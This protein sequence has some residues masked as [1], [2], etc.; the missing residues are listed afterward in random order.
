L[1]KKLAEY[2]KAGKPFHFPVAILTNLVFI[3]RTYSHF[4]NMKKEISYLVESNSNNRPN[5]LQPLLSGNTESLE[6]EAQPLPIHDDIPTN[7]VKVWEILEDLGPISTNTAESVERILSDFPTLNESDILQA[8]LL[9]CNNSTGSDDR[10]TRAINYTY[11]AT[12]THDWNPLLNDNNPKEANITWKVNNFLEICNKKYKIDWSNVVAALDR[13]HL[14]F[15]D[16]QA[17]VFLFKSFQ[18]FKKVPGF[19]F[20]ARL[21]LGKWRNFNSQINFV[22]NMISAA[23]PE[24][25]FFNEVQ[26][27]TVSSDLYSERK[28]AALDPPVLQ[29]FSSLELLETMIELSDS[30]YYTEIRGLFDLPLEKC[31]DLL[32]YSLLEINPRTGIELLNELYTN[33]VLHYISNYTSSKSIFDIIWKANP[34]ILVNAFAELYNKNDYPI[35]INTILEIIQ[36]IPDSLLTVLNSRDYEFAIAL[37]VSASKTNLVNPED[38]IPNRMKSIGDRFA[39]ATLRYLTNAVFEPCRAAEEGRIKDCIEKLPLSLDSV[40]KIFQL[41]LDQNVEGISNINKLNASDLYKELSSYFP[42]MEA[43]VPP[44]EADVVANSMI[45]KVF[46]ASMSVPDFIDLLLKYKTSEVENERDIAM[47]I[48]SNLLDE[49]RFFSTYKNKML[50]IM[51]QIYGFLLKNDVIEGKTRDFAFMIILDTVKQKESRKIFDFGVNALVIFK[52]RFIEWPAKASQ[53]FL[54][55]NLRN[56]SFDLLEQ[57]QYDLNTNN[58]EI[59]LPEEYLVILNARGPKPIP[60]GEAIPEANSPALNSEPDNGAQP[61]NSPRQLTLEDTIDA[62]DKNFN[63]VPE[64]SKTKITAAMNSC[65]DSNVFQKAHEIRNLLKDDTIIIWLARHLIVQKAQKDSAQH[66]L[67]I[68]LIEKIN[69]KE[70]FNVVIKETYS[71]LTFVIQHLFNTSEKV[72]LNP[73]DKN[74][75]KYLGSWLGSLTIARNK[76]IIMKEFD[77]KALIMNAHEAKKLDFVLP[78]VC[79]ILIQGNQPGSVFKPNNAWMNAILSILAEIGEMSDIKMALKYEIQ[80]LF[81]NLLIKEG[82]IIPSKVFQ[83]R[84]ARKKAAQQ[85]HIH[86]LVTLDSYLR[87]EEIAKWL[88]L[89]TVALRTYSTEVDFKTVTSTALSTAI[90][91]TLLNLTDASTLALR[92]SKRLVLK[93]FAFEQDEKNLVHGLELTIQSLA[94]SLTLVTSRRPLTEHFQQSLEQLLSEYEIPNKQSLIETLVTNNLDIGGTIIRN[95]VVRGALYDA[96]NDQEILQAIEKRKNAR[97]KGTPIYDEPLVHIWNSLPDPIKPNPQGLTREELKIY[98]EFRNKESQ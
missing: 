30:D 59:E 53:L 79:K 41:I 32:L 17:F 49:S 91:K 61:I 35:S 31:P 45:E 14:K 3:L 22:L 13:P 95:E 18:R 68:L 7:L 96:S 48:V 12:K 5:D 67:Y 24:L 73:K 57:I 37:A 2:C 27:K 92:T 94:E 10:D 44:T 81:R 74:I 43:K 66:E 58:V 62:F 36:G 46:D 60:N 38:W 93:D 63:E 47:C 26:K 84:K 55:E 54:I 42:E 77:I 69:M 65:N 83:T 8:L 50:I 85:I 90:K 23:Q 97:L 89:N 87:P 86:T 78:L 20:P 11:Q 56:L 98:E 21:L 52:E 28:I 75:L 34:Q 88:R 51:A 82:D 70:V 4:E 40:I 9:M 6:A 80:M 39:K 76:P 64:E 33:L 72:T 19:K 1:K 29:F 25:V 16:P 15:K 71:L